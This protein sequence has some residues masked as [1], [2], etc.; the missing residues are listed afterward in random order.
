MRLEMKFLRGLTGKDGAGIT[1]Y[2]DI[3]R[4]NLA[5]FVR[6]ICNDHGLGIG[7]FSMQEVERR[8]KESKHIFT[9]HTNNTGNLSII[10]LKGLIRMFKRFINYD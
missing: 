10:T 9:H 5:Y 8:N 2:L 6:Q 4:Y 7:V 1:T 3:L